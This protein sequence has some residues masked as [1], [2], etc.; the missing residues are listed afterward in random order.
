MFSVIFKD[1]AFKLLPIHLR[2]GWILYYLTA[3][4]KPLQDLNDAFIIFKNKIDYKLS[5]NGQIINLEHI[6]N[7]TYDDI[8]RGIYIE[9]GANVV[10]TYLFNKIESK[11][12][13]F[14]FQQSEASPHFLKTNSENMTTVQFI[15]KVPVAVVY[16]EY[17]MRQLVDK[18]KQAGVIYS[19]ETY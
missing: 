5:F 4:L 18:Y 6:L 14:L 19:I 15:I 9:D 12:P 16:D 13:L 2:L 1:I 3:G 10:Y 17:I 11:P 7:D 8:V